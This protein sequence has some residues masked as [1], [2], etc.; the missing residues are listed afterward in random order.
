MA[1]EQS[2][3]RGE[4]WEKSGVQGIKERT[5]RKGTKE[6]EKQHY[7]VV[8]PAVL[9]MRNSERGHTILLEGYLFLLSL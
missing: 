5:L 9:Y 2:Y 6:K 1:D 4:H 8:W 7:I 3:A